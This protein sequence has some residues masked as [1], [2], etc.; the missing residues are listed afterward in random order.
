MYKT[1]INLN[2]NYPFILKDLNLKFT[3]PTYWIN[4]GSEFLNDPSFKNSLN[5]IGEKE[6]ILVDVSEDPLNFS[7]RNT[8]I[9]DK[10]FII[11]TANP[12]YSYQFATQS[13][14]LK[15]ICPY[16]TIFFN[17]L[18]MHTKANYYLNRNNVNYKNLKKKRFLLM[19]RRDTFYR[20]LTNYF[21]HKFNLFEYGYVSHNRIDEQQS[22]VDYYLKLHKDILGDY[23]DCHEYSLKRHYL[24]NP[25]SK[26][27]ATIDFNAYIDYLNH[28]QFEIVTESVMYSSCMFVSEKILKPIIYKKPFILI[29]SVNSLKYIQ[30]LGFKTF[31]PII[32][33]DYDSENNNVLRLAKLLKEAKR[34]CSKSYE[35]LE[36]DFLS[37][38]DII[39]YNYNHFISKDWH[40]NIQTEV[41][42]YIN[43]NITNR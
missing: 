37:I 4:G 33:E 12:L 39:E 29:G 40:F 6:L 35:E 15:K 31:H 41:Q 8:L 17:K 3:V 22:N 10:R 2:T 24:D 19:S 38:Q 43:E 21:V 25:A 16:K 26:Q 13:N 14:S 27:N 11:I 5:N 42:K 1:E 34:L 36:K 30:K 20:R 32:N 7:E 28:V 9:K 23:D 18:F